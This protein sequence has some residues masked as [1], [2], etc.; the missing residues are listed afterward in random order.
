MS[1]ED[2]E[3][4]RFWKSEMEKYKALFEGAM[5]VSANKEYKQDI[6]SLLAAGYLAISPKRRIVLGP[7]W[8]EGQ[9]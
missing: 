3:T 8:R 1:P 5:A 7:R 9:R 2:K 4:L 6:L